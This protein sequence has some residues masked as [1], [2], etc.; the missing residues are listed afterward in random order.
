[1][2]I[3]K[4]LISFLSVIISLFAGIYVLF[5]IGIFI[6]L[7][8]SGTKNTPR[9]YTQFHAENFSP[10]ANPVNNNAPDE[11]NLT[12]EHPPKELSRFSEMANKF[13][14]RKTFINKVQQD[15]RASNAPSFCNII[16]NEGLKKSFHLSEYYKTEGRRAFDNPIFRLK[17]ARLNL[18]V[19]LLAGI[20]ENE[21]LRRFIFYSSDF[22]RMT[23]LE[24]SS[25]VFHLENKI[26]PSFYSFV[27]HTDTYIHESQVLSRIEKLRASCE[28]EYRE[29]IQT[30]C[31][32]E[33]PHLSE[34]R[35]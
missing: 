33:M 24:K 5:F 28:S 4:I 15:M 11:G 10:T 16:C 35:I 3:K 19:D 2:K 7:N 21:V 31:I 12:P 6:F 22:D 13:S 26:I 1:M 25:Y 18:L 34:D 8:S 14:T 9:E 20:F 32:E 27:Q 23:A 30:R 29:E 17:Y